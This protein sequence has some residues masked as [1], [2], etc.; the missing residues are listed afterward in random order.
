MFYSVRKSHGC[1]PCILQAG[2]C[3]NLNQLANNKGRSR[4]QTVYKARLLTCD[5]F[6]VIVYN[7]VNLVFISLFMVFQ[8]EVSTI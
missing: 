6:F 2:F 4:P 3:F 5:A 1:C 8:F 7:W